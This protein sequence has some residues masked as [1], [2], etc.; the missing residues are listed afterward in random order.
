MPGGPDV[1]LASRLDDSPLE[2]STTAGPWR[3][4]NYDGEFHGEVSV[5]EALE[6]SLNVASA[7]LGQKVGAE[8]VAHMARRL[9]VESDLLKN[10]Q[11]PSSGARH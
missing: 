8:R 4:R 7:R 1:T 9:G 6:R 10:P 2:V 11:L 5:R 3:P